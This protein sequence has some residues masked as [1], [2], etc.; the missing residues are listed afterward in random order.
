VETQILGKFK[1]I[2]MNYKK[3]VL[4]LVIMVLVILSDRMT[5][6]W[7]VETLKGY[8][9]QS[10]LG[11]SFRIIYAE[12]E[13]AFLSLGSDLPENVRFWVL[14]IIP[15]LALGYFGFTLFF[16]NE[17]G[18]WQRI[19][20]A[21]IIAGGGSNIIDRILEGKVVDFLNIGIGDLRSG[22]FNIADMAIMAGLFLILPMAFKSSAPKKQEFVPSEGE[23]AVEIADEI[24]EIKAIEE[25]TEE[26]EEPS[27]ENK[28][29]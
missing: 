22:I 18:P 9:S 25:E 2:F 21:F 17:V 10:Y 6:V 8:P 20:F 23:N 12:N 11:D 1:V 19:A 7:A 3:F 13:G 29:E 28:G 15:I 24:A 4:P 14:A 27:K 16:N 5:K 26:T